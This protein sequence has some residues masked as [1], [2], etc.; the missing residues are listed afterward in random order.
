MSR[1]TVAYLVLGMV[2]CAVA[3]NTASSQRAAD[4]PSTSAPPPATASQPPA[5]S[6]APVAE[7]SAVPSTA[8]AAAIA[9]PTAPPRYAA[10]PPAPGRVLEERTRQPG[11]GEWTPL[12]AGGTV[13]GLPVLY[14]TRVHTDRVK[15]WVYVQ[16]VAVDLTRTTL[17]LAAGTTEPKSAVVPATERPGLVPAEQ[18]AQLAAVFNGGFRAEHG[19]YSM[20]VAPHVFFEPRADA[21]VI[22][23]GKRVEVGPWET[24]KTQ[25]EAADAFRQTP[26]CLVHGGEL[27]PDLKE[28]RKLRHWGRSIEK[29]DEV[30]R[31][32]VGVD[33]SGEI[34]FYGLGEWTTPADLA[35][36]M[37]AA[38][39]VSAA[40][41]DINWSYTKF[42][43]FDADSSGQLRVSGG[44]IEELEYPQRGYTSRPSYRD[45]F[46][47][48]RAQEK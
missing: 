29:K 26:R 12:E 25:A 18:Q 16:V 41:L 48:T 10:F 21:C 35:R 33:A 11:D 17:H 31:S 19:G 7:P 47:I 15:K 39:A 38:G 23:L 30:R 1:A 8:H 28:A 13:A 46:Y 9:D 43:F 24:L 44:L 20:K 40:Q 42:L 4:A 36:G 27:H 32:A 6:S 22:V 14:T 5:V 2:G 3:C 37:Q 45:F 34:L